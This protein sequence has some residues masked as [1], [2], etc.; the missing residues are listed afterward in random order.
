MHNGYRVFPLLL[1]LLASGLA[2]AAE[3]GGVTIGGTRLIFDG[4]KKE[5]SLSVS[6]SDS[7]PYLI[8]SWIESA[9]NNP[10]KPPFIITPPLFRLDGNQ[11]N[12]LRIVNIGGLL[13]ADR[14]SLYW[15]NVKAI[16][17][18][19]APDN[20]NTLQIAVRTR[21]KLIFRPKTLKG[22]PEQVTHKLKWR[23]A[24]RRLTV[25]NPTPFYMNFNEVTI[26]NHP[27]TKA[28]FVAPMSSVTFDTPDKVV[29]QVSWKIISDFGGVGESHSQDR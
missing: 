4:G 13:P 20:A 16:P 28:T 19:T 14:E 26:G 9:D 12:L 10:R 8:Q 5:A 21:L 24:G 22:T 15:L 18:N 17:T 11:Q 29:G 6:N 1:I 7:A 3:S 2:A 25:T 27:I 23:Q